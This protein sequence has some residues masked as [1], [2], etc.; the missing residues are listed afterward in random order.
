MGRTMRR[1]I[2]L[3]LCLCLFAGVASAEFRGIPWGASMQEVL[4]S[5]GEPIDRS[6]DGLVYETEIGGLAAHASFHFVGDRL[7]AALYYFTEQ[8]ASYNSYIDDF[9]RI[10][11]L[12]IRKYRDPKED[13]VRWEDDLFKNNPEDWGTAVAIE[14]LKFLAEWETDNSN[15]THML[16]G[17]NYKV[18]HTIAYHSLSMGNLWYQMRETEDLEQL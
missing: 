4:E 7:V 5:E 17:K 9:R 12:L 3:Q 15:I 11:K 16:L 10:K 18:T 2:L 6:A 1:L 8:Y 13:V 14:H